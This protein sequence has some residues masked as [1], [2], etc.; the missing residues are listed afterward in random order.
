MKEQ[1]LYPPL[2][3][4]LEGL[5]YEV[6]GEIEGC[7]VVA[8]RLGE[9]GKAEP[10]LIVELK[11]QLNLGVILQAVDRFAMTQSVY[12][13]VPAG[14]G[15]LKRERK[16]ILKLFRRLGLGLITI[17]PNIGGRSKK[18]PTGIVHI[19]L[20]PVP[21]EARINKRRAAR[22]KKEF[23]T[24]IGDTTPGGQATNMGVLTSYRQRAILIGGYLREAGPTKA[25]AVAKELSDPK[26]RDLMY[27]NV[28]GW[29]EAEGK[30]IYR[31]NPA[32]KKELKVWEGK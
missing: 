1:D 20:D 10:L 23:T 28:Y 18:T 6:K 11:L 26:A 14:M 3:R 2:K 16:R 21:S 4:T 9:D 8:Q 12:V 17:D 25:S 19:V 13:G 22:L 30:G 32:G 7:D 27:N 29:F 5:G 15:T 24:R 31:L